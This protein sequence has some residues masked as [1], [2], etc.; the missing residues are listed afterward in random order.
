MLGIKRDVTD[1]IIESLKNDYVLLLVGARQTGKTT[2]LKQVQEFLTQKGYPTHFLNLED[3]TYLDLLNQHPRNLLKIFSIDLNQRNYIIADEVQYL[4]NPTNFLKFLYDEYREKIKF[5]VS[6]S[7]AFYLDEKFKDSLAG[8]KTIFEIR[9]L[10]FFEF[11]RFKNREDLRK[12]LPLASLSQKEEIRLLYDEYL[13]WGGFPRVVLSPLAEKEALLQELAY[14]Y[15]KKD[16]YESRI[17]QDEAVYKLLKILADQ[18][19]NLVNINELSRTLGLSKTAIENHLYVMQKSYH[20][21]VVRP[22]YQNVRKELTK[23]PKIYFYDL[24]LRNFFCSD[25]SPPSTRRNL[26]GLLENAVFRQLLDHYQN[27]D[28]IKFWRTLQ[29]NEVDFVVEG[30][31]AFEVKTSSFAF[32]PSKYRQFKNFYADVRLNLV[33]YK[34]EPETPALEPYEI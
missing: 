23:M 26:G 1:K 31:E 22:F 34:K 5:L 10:S 25:F 17:R 16:I 33:V 30:K 12:A 7:S 28:K 2:I 27:L 18:I 8:R 3:P 24:G 11:L 29:K 4:K 32:N 14:S 13:T 20:L 21:A 6:G 15:I 19:G 9:T